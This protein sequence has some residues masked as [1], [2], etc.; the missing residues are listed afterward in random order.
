MKI[1]DL[2]A[3]FERVKAANPGI[4]IDVWCSCDSGVGGIREPMV[5]ESEP[6]HCIDEI[7]LEKRIIVI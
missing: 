7:P 2:I 6:L 4:E 1:Y 3:F 5:D